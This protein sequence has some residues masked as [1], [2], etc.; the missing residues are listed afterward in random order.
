M[1]RTAQRATAGTE[2][3]YIK[4]FKTM[5]TNTDSTMYVLAINIQTGKREGEKN[6][7]SVINGKEEVL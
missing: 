1:L 3:M 4:A 6:H 2:L 5:L 7:T